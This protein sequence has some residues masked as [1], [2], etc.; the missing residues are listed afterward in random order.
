MIKLDITKAYDT[1]S[2]SF[3]RDVMVG[4]GFPTR[5]VGLIM[6]IARCV[7]STSSS[8]MINGNCH[9]FFNSKR[10][11]RQGD[12]MAPTLFLFCIE[13]L[14]R[15]LNTKAREGVFNY[16]KDCV[17]LGITH[18]AFADDLMLFSRGDF[19]SVQIL[20][21]ALSHFSSVSGL[22][23]NPTKSNIFIAGKYRE[24]SEDILDLASFPRGHLPVRYL[25]LP[26]ASQ[27]I[28]EAD[29]APLFKSVDGFLSKWATLKLSYAGKL[30]LI[31]AVIQGVQSF[32]L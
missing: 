2:W 28:S 1:V 11:L 17:E 22:N 24:I 15:V 14:S 29:Y 20:I 5:F 3:L 26:L 19:Q 13:Y 31:R 18:L 4:L 32:W 21:D 8:L 9:G 7:S 27:R 23:L 25:G 6:E 30:E 16:H 12:L 10:G